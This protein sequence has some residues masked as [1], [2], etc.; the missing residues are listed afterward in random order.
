M[1]Q[2]YTPIVA[3]I[4]KRREGPDLNPAPVGESL[5]WER[6]EDSWR[7]RDLRRPSEKVRPSDRD[8]RRLRLHIWFVA[9]LPKDRSPA[10]TSAFFHLL[11]SC[12]L[13]LLSSIYS[14]WGSGIA[15]ASIGLQVAF[16]AGVAT[17]AL[18]DF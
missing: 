14:I 8:G 12:L 7:Q 10:P 2:K 5:S 4:S 17:S 15:G 18:Q 3:G 11:L 13:P 16:L 9:E 6:V 1:S